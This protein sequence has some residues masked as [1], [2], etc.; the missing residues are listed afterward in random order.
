MASTSSSSSA[1]APAPSSAPAPAFAPAPASLPSPTSAPS[2]SS[3][4]SASAAEAVEERLEWE[5]YRGGSFAQHMLA[6]SCAGVAE[7][8]LMYPLDTVKTHQ[9][10]THSSGGGA[11]PLAL[12]L[13][14]FLRRDGFVRLWRGAPAVV[15]GSIP[16]HAAYFSAYEV[17]K[18]SL[19][20]NRPGHHPL[21]AAVT[22]ALATTVHD[23]VATP[24]DV[25]KQR[26]QLGYYRGVAHCVRSMAA[27]EGLLSLWRSY[28]TTLLMNMP[29]AAA[30]VSAN[31]SFKKLLVPVT[32]PLSLTTYL[33]SGAG[34]GAIAAAA[35]CPL[36]VVKTRLQTQG[37]LDGSGGG[38]G[39][40]SSGDTAARSGARSGAGA[41]AVVA[42]AGGG[43]GG[44]AATAAA[45][46]AAGS[47][48]GSSGAAAAAGG[49]SSLRAA[50]A[51][52][53]FASAAHGLF[54]SSPSSSAS[55]AAAA[56]RGARSGH[57]GQVALLSTQPASHLLRPQAAPPPPPLPR[58]RAL[59]AVE[60]ARVMLRE[61]GLGA[62]FKGVRAR[63]A[64]HAP[65]QAVSW[66]TYELVKGFLSRGGEGGSDAQ[67]PLT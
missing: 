37:V 36:D 47:V 9:Q 32:G 43:G 11:R 41:A 48:G 26:L 15:L 5:E 25:V 65:S 2:A 6:G 17:A 23:G 56:V 44:S 1:P 19:G 54:S 13:R 42:V 40:G 20:A 63:V 18:E 49:A 33:L 57:V 4:L 46:A 59:G 52:A 38:S 8:L 14:D 16:S 45:A 64:I 55:A 53:A 35:T 67:R 34:A 21:A 60:L 12:G 27:E 10:A 66:A 50:T 31:E 29:Y 22:G 24:M 39:G 51:K 62:F 58:P 3:A 61:E 7:H 30:V 28:P